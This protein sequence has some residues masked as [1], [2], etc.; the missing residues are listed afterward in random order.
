VPDTCD[1]NP[2]IAPLK[3]A[4]DAYVLDA[5]VGAVRAARQ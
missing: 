5:I 3:L 1:Q 4:E 2:A